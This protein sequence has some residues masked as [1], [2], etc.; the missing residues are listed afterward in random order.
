MANDEM[1]K[2]ETVRLISKIY[3]VWREKKPSAK[4]WAWGS[5]PLMERAMPVLDNHSF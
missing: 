3:T 1:L 2:S 4:Q 5:N